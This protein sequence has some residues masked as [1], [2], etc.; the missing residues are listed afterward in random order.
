M[1][2]PVYEQLGRAIREARERRGMEQDDLAARVGVGQQA[3]STWERGK[4]RPRR[5]MVTAVAEALQVAEELVLDAGGYRATAS[6]RPAARPLA[7]TLPLDELPPDRF[8]D[9][10]T[11]VMRALHPDGHASRYGGP[12]EK[13]FGI[14]VL[15]AADDRH[16]ATAQCKR[17]RQFGPAAIRAAVAEVTVSADKHYLF[18]SRTTATP[19]ARAEMAT[20][21]GWQLWD[22]EDISRFIRALPLDE[23]VRL[24]DTYFP[25]H[26]EPFL[27]VPQPAPWL[28]PEELF[29]DSRG[30]V[31]THDWTLVGRADDLARLS[32]VLYDSPGT[33]QALVGRGGVGKTRLLRAIAEASPDSTTQVRILPSGVTVDAADFELLPAT[34]PLVVMIDDAHERNDIPHVVAGVW[35]RNRTASVLIATRP[36][37]WDR[38]RT[39]L[40]RAALL[41]DG[42]APVQLDDLKPREA[43]ALARE[44][45]GESHHA[46]VQRL[47]RL[48]LDCPLATVVGGVLIRRGRLDPAQL[49]RDDDVRD[50]I[51]RGFRD[52]LIADPYVSDPDTRAA[53]LDAVAA[54]QPFRTDEQAFKD[55][56]SAIAGKPYDV[57]SKHLR[58]LEDAGVLRRRGASVRITPDLLGDVILAQACYDERANTP[59]GYLDRV[60]AAADGQVLQHLFVNVSRVDWQVRR[61]NAARASLAD[62]LWEPLAE[63]IRRADIRGREALVHLLSRVAYFQPERAL[64][65]ARWLIDHPTERVA[66]EHAV[67]AALRRPTYQDVLAA[68]PPVVKAAAYTF[69]LLPAAL[70][71]LWELAESDTRPTNQHPDHPL[72]VLKDLAAFEVGKPA[73]Y[74]DAIV[75]AASRWFADGQAVSPFDVLEPLLATEGS[76]QTYQDFTF[77][78]E[79]FPLNVS[80]VGPIRERVIALALAEAQAP[81]V[82]RAAAGVHALEAALRY[83]TGMYGRPI[84]DEERACWTPEF[85]EAIRRLGAVA[86]G[87]GI[88]P[89]VRVAVRK[90]LN[91]HSTYSKTVTRT[92]AEAVLATLPDDLENRVALVLHDGWGNLLRDRSEGFEASQH[93]IEQRLAATVADLCQLTD[94]QIVTLL[95]E[96]LS[97]DRAAF[98]AASRHPGPFVAAL[99]KT[100]PSLAPKLLDLAVSGQAADVEPLLPVVLAVYAE[101]DP[102]PALNRA[103][104]LVRRKPGELK[105]GVA[106]ALGWNRGARPLAD[107]EL[108]LLLDF[109]ADPDPTVRQ[110]AAVVAQRLAK[111]RPTDACR[112]AAAVDFS[113]SP[114]LADELFASFSPQHY[115]LSWD[116]LTDAQRA[117][118]RHR[119]V[120]LPDV[121]QYWITAFLSERSAVEPAWVFELLQDRVS[122]AEALETLDGYDAMPYHW[123]NALRVREHANFVSHLRRLHA[124]IAD[125]P[126]SWKRQEMGGDVFRECAGRYDDIV[127]S[128]LAEALAS[129][130]EADV[131]AV[132]AVLRKAQRTLIWDAPE[133]VANALHAANRFGDD[134]RDQMMGALWASTTADVRT[135]APGHP[136]PEDVEQRDQS[137]ALA[138]RLPKGSIE[139]DFYRSMAASAEQSIA[140]SVEDRRDDGRDW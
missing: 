7:R 110:A 139:Y 108:E 57:L 67:W 135:G 5:A 117:L 85:V 52:T 125:A 87:S 92:V 79:P 17:H 4:S 25:G 132:A 78:F 3:V 76:R 131:R 63:E 137:N 50:A 15:I 18:L 112:L 70:D 6:V 48:T 23:A 82:R 9:I 83:P 42:L 123:D 22:G 75:D 71:L 1:I 20:H 47:A 86:A 51:M 101:L 107:G 102:P 129:T 104:E 2:K 130:N 111:E 134:C 46:V 118:I 68:L 8:E 45:L 84:T 94:E 88:D 133:F 136:F 11:D 31:F 69:E 32:A 33:L 16:L 60:R 41:P 39:D 121:G 122:H 26:R 91:W 73:V 66:D 34:S 49:E 27:G 138:A 54:V 62:A 124:W 93:R 19:G 30:Q 99:V 36:Y 119:L 40:A 95:N 89:A 98:G 106:Q 10:V 77:T 116:H 43:E 12:G 55:A 100:R 61:R 80:V 128:V 74:N 127:L 38:L 103:R 28:P 96:R 115:G 53:V 44:A 114:H 90:T 97:A 120:L 14:D 37:G 35:R 64:E 58:S 105:P 113:D 140:R 65:T 56:L 81:D 72:R 59:T 21:P 109:A 24:V 126:D 13:Q 29:A